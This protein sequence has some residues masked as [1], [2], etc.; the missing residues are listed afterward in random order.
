MKQQTNWALVRTYHSR[1]IIRFQLII[2]WRSRTQHNKAIQRVRIIDRSRAG[3]TSIDLIRA[4]RRPNFGRFDWKSEGNRGPNACS[5]QHRAER[6]SWVSNCKTKSWITD[7]QSGPES[8]MMTG[9]QAF[10]AIMINVLGG[11]KRLGLEKLDDL[12][13]SWA[14]FY[15]LF[16]RLNIY[17]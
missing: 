3:T 6:R 15:T 16:E 11:F 5:P 4:A 9:P 1:Y 7:K 17:L 13:T 10:A 12:L 8:V 14:D 2:L